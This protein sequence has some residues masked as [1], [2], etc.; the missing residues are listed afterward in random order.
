MDET[1]V[2][3][4]VAD[5]EAHS[6]IL[7]FLEQF[8]SFVTV[9]VG[10]ALGGVAAKRV[11]AVLVPQEVAVAR[12]EDTSGGAYRSRATVAEIAI[13][14]KLPLWYRLWRATISLHPVIV[15]GLCGLTPIPIANW[16]PSHTA[17]HVLWFA[18]AGALSGQVFEI[19]NRIK[20]IGIAVVRQRLG[21]KS[22]RPPPPDP[23]PPAPPAL[24]DELEPEEKRKA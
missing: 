13:D 23:P 15:G 24:A 3:A 9:S 8:W 10:V 21:V 11:V 6:K 7:F 14:P 17:A 20:E 2:A 12:A 18:L 19:G 22:D 16:V 1:T 4:A 5:P